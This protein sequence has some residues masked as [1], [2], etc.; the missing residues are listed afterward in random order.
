MKPKLHFPVTSL[1]LATTSSAWATVRYVN[2]NNAKPTPPCTNWAAAVI[3]FSDIGNV[4]AKGNAS[5]RVGGPIEIT[6]AE[7]QSL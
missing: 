6:K 1:L 2:V 7:N 3:P 4:I 5:A